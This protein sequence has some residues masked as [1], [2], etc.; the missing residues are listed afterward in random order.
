MSRNFELL[1]RVAKDDFFSLPE[2]PAP[3]PKKAAPAI[4]FKKEPPDAEI[5]KLVQRL[6]TQ[7]GKGSGPK[8]VSFSGIARDDRSSWICARAAEALSE[9]ADSSI[10]VVEGNLWAPQLHIHLS[11]VNSIGW[12]EALATRDAIRNFAMPLSR[13][14]LWLIPGGQWKPGMHFS[15]ESYRERFTELRETFD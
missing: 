1:Q 12:A 3:P 8:V 15:R 5:T 10:C 14:N 13:P 11:A 7:A 2:E 4:P 9:Q 6:F